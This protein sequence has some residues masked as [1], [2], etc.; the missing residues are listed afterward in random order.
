MRGFV[1]NSPFVSVTDGP[2]AA[3][4]S[5]DGDQPAVVAEGRPGS[6]TDGRAHRIRAG[7]ERR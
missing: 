2:A 1:E 4:A 7:H 5:G 6:F 3:A